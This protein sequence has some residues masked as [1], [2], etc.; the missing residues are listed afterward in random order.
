MS[1]KQRLTAFDWL[2]PNIQFDFSR[3]RLLGRTLGTGLGLLIFVLAV[4]VVGALAA[5]IAAVF[6]LGSYQGQVTDEAIRNIGLVLAAVFGAPFIAWRSW[7]AQRQADIAEQG[8]ITDRINKAVQGLGA[9]KTVRRHRSNQEGTL[10]YE[11]SPDGQID[12][13]KPIFDELTLPN[14]EVRIGSIYALERVANESGADRAQIIEIFCAYV[15]NNNHAPATFPYPQLERFSTDEQKPDMDERFSGGAS[16]LGRDWST[17]LKPPRP[18][19]RAAIAVLLRVIEKF[20]GKGDSI[21][22]PP[23]TFSSANLQRADFRGANLAG[24]KFEDCQLDGADLEKTDLAD[25]KFVNCTLIGAS[26]N[27]ANLTGTNFLESKLECVNA[28][29]IKSMSGC[30]F[31]NCDCSGILF[32]DADMSNSHFVV[33]AR[34]AIFSAE[35][36]NNTIFSMCDIR[37]GVISA[38]SMRQLSIHA[39]WVPDSGVQLME[40]IQM[41]K[42]AVGTRRAKLMRLFVHPSHPHLAHSVSPSASFLKMVEV[43]QEGAEKFDP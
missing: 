33:T 15:S 26:I 21:D 41:N 6:H 24:A 42:H 14:L 29:S 16:G 32:A 23:L 1:G 19:T 30:S 5:F 10:L 28:A 4:G 22:T 36:M 13:N 2:W 3:A 38:H 31:W 9:E 37:D 11:Y 17:K 34:K 7:V 25:A 8:H 27:S 20:S 18:D 39:T 43:E 12:P 35:S 40:R